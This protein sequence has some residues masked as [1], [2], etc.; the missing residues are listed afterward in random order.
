VPELPDVE[1]MRQYLESTAMYQEI[2]RVQV[3]SKQVLCETTVEGLRDGLVRGSFESTCRHGKYMFVALG[4][5]EDRF[6]GLHFGM[7]GGLTYFGDLVD[8][9]EYGQIRFHFASGNYLAYH[10]IRKLGEVRLI[11]D[12]EQFVDDKDLGPDALDP[13]L[14]LAA[15]KRIVTGRR[16]MVKAL[17]LD[18]HNIAGIGNVYADEILF[19]ADVHPRTKINALDGET[20]DHLFSTMSEV[21]RTA[22][23]CQAQPER[24]PDSY[25][26]AYRHE[27]GRCPECGTKLARVRVSSRTAYYCPVRQRKEQEG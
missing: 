18:Q 21:L 24:F 14:D 19:Q 7:T 23:E 17:L 20:I 3:V 26:T 5:E 10:S 16:V 1:T 13:D 12:V 9:P 11:D 25:I 4:G 27:E 6:L 2:A 15:F 22:V 8:E